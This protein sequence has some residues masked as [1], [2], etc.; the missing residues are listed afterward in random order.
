MTEISFITNEKS[1]KTRYYK[2][3]FIDRK[4]KTKQNIIIVIIIIK[5]Y[6]TT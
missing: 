2:T 4:K 1:N 5:K 3:N 6:I